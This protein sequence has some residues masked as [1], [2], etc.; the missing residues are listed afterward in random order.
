MNEFIDAYSDDQIYLSMIKELVDNHPVESTVPEKIK[1]SSYCRLWTV[2]M[3]GSIEAMVKVWDTGDFLWAD[4]A[5]YFDKK[6]NENRVEDLKNAFQL[7]GVDVDVEMFKDFL[8][9]KYIRNSYIHSNWN[10]T[11]RK[12]AI[13]RNF[14]GD[15]MNFEPRHFDRMQAV[16]HHI[17]NG[18]GMIHASNF[19][20]KRP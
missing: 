3:V 5:A 11:Q 8:A 2:M 12:Y 1:Y 9:I 6:S 7:R 16:H 17:M 18:L 19:A 13:S 20:L 15:V 4:I 14:P 10:E